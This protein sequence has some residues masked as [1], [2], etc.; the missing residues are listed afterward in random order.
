MNHE[1]DNKATGWIL[2][3]VKCRVIGVKIGLEISSEKSREK[4]NKKIVTAYFSRKT[5]TIFFYRPTIN[6]DN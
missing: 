3:V 4:T 2:N 5:S 6:S 1:F